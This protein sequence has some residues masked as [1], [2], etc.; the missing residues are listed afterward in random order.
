M[1]PTPFSTVC[2]RAHLKGMDDEAWLEVLNEQ[3]L[4]SVNARGR[5]FLSHTKLHGKFTLRVAI[6]NLRTTEKD[7]QDLWMEL[8]TYLKDMSFR[9]NEV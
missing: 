8:Q 1:A 6:G 3:I 5:F 9:L 4:N 2:F 7:I